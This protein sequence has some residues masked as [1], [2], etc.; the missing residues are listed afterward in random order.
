MRVCSQI[1]QLI[2]DKEKKR[3]N[4]CLYRVIEPLR[5]LRVQ[6]LVNNGFVVV[7]R[8]KANYFINRLRQDIIRAIEGGEGNEIKEVTS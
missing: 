3:M 7:D 2:G 6:E 4:D 5:D 8:D 1:V